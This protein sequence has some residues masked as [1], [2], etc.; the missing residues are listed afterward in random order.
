V[1]SDVK[2]LEVTS[3]D[4]AAAPKVARGYDLFFPETG[5]RLTLRFDELGAKRGGAP[6]DKTYRFDPTHIRT[7][8]AVNLDEAAPAN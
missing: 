6:N 5:S 4:P 8:K 1:L 3:G 7:A 2:P